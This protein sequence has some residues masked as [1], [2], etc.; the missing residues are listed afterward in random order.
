MRAASPHLTTHM[1]LKFGLFPSDQP[2]LTRG[3]T[4]EEKRFHTNP[5][6]LTVKDLTD[7]AVPL[8]LSEPREKA[9]P[10]DLSIARPSRMLNSFEEPRMHSN[11]FAGL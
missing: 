8:V 2:E 4:S 6:D 5:T 9:D 7:E 10:E 3:I 1:Y 11:I